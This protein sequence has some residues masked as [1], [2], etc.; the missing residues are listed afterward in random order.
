MPANGDFEMPRLTVLF[1]VLTLAMVGLLA[2]KSSAS[3][4][5]NPPQAR[6]PSPMSRVVFYCSPALSG[7][8]VKD[9]CGTRVCEYAI[10]CNNLSNMEDSVPGHA[11]CPLRTDG[12]CA[13]YSECQ[14]SVL[15]TKRDVAEQFARQCD[16]FRSQS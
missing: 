11:Y 1:T 5:A 16:K 15:K 12:S 6:L 8:L 3:E 13:P 10:V 7:A 4:W 14:V 2:P 9:A